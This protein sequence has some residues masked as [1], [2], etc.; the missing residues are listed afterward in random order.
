MIEIN[1]EEGDFSNEAALILA[2]RKDKLWTDITT[3]RDPVTN[4]IQGLTPSLSEFA[5]IEILPGQEVGEITGDRTP[6]GPIEIEMP[7]G[8]FY[9]AQ[10]SRDLKVW[11]TI[12]EGVS[13]TFTD[14]NTER[15]DGGR[16]FYQVILNEAG[17]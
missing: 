11:T 14:S 6:E 3:G 8:R 5:V 7:A 17:N 1:Y 12:A 13:G 9:D 10:F 16:V 2:H 15:T 4:K